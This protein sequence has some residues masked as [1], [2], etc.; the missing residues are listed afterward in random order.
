MVDHQILFTHLQHHLHVNSMALTWFKAYF[1]DHAKS[2]LDKIRV[3]QNNAIRAVLCAEF[4]TPCVKLYHDAKLEPVSVCMK[5]TLCKI[6]Y[7]GLNNIGAPIYNAMFN[8]DV[9][10]RNLR[11]SDKLLAIV[12]KVNTKFGEHNML[13]RGPIYWN[14]L[15]LHIKASSSF[16]QF[17]VAIKAYD[18]F[19]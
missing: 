9:S 4:R 1:T 10:T 11:S 13:F 7:K 2:T 8:Y 3:Q 12:P 19:D 6:V 5:K 16:E 15:P 14:Q 18:G 17:K